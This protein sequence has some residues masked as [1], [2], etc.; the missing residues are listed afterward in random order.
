[1]KKM[2][3]SHKKVQIPCGHGDILEHESGVFLFVRAKKRAKSSALQP[4]F[5]LSARC[6][7]LHLQQP[8][9]LNACCPRMSSVFNHAHWL[10]ACRSSQRRPRAEIFSAIN[11]ECA[12][13]V[14]AAAART[15]LPLKFPCA[16]LKFKSSHHAYCVLQIVA[17]CVCAVCNG[18]MFFMWRRLLKEKS[19]H[20]WPL[21]VQFRFHI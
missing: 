10:G 13:T 7:R 1:M 17:S 12:I 11:Y 3:T 2:I 4:N 5:T 9:E 6:K 19:V 16:L 20:L 21:Y 14:S 8:I 15:R 18:L